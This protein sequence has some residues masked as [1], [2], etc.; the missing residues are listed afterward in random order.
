MRTIEIYPLNNFH[1]EHAAVVTSHAVCWLSSS[2]D[3]LKGICLIFCHCIL[4]AK[5]NS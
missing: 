2:I 1:I 4:S 5:N 3:D